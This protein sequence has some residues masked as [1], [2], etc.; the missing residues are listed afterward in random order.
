MKLV[1]RPRKCVRFLTAQR[2]VPL[3]QI[4]NIV[5]N[6]ASWINV[7][8][9]IS[10]HLRPTIHFL[11]IMNLVRMVNGAKKPTGLNN[12]AIQYRKVPFIE[13]KVFFERICFDRKHVFLWK[14]RPYQCLHC[15]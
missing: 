7:H 11:C 6:S 3:G 12:A 13:L 14:K 2:Q 15:W 8:G 4:V 5:A 10:S 1:V 9:H